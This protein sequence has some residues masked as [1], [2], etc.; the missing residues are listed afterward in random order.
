VGALFGTVAAHGVDGNK[1]IDSTTKA[2]VLGLGIL[3]MALGLIG[4]AIYARRELTKIIM[5]EQNEIVMEERADSELAQSFMNGATSE[6]DDSCSFEGLENPQPGNTSDDLSLPSSQSSSPTIRH[7]KFY[8]RPW[9]PDAVALELPI[10]PKMLNTYLSPKRDQVDVGNDEPN[11]SEVQSIGK[12]SLSASMPVERCPDNFQ[13]ELD[14]PGSRISSS[15]VSFRRH[16]V[17]NHSPENIRIGR[18][19]TS[20]SPI[21]RSSSFQLDDG[22]FH[23]L[24][25]IDESNV[26]SDYKTPTKSDL[27]EILNPAVIEAEEGTRRRCHTDPIDIESAPFSSGAKKHRRPSESPPHSRRDKSPA[28]TPSKKGRLRTRLSMDP[29]GA[30]QSTQQQSLP[31]DDSTTKLHGSNDIYD[32]TTRSTPMLFPQRKE[33]QSRDLR[34]RSSSSSSLSPMM[35]QLEL[36]RNRRNEPRREEHGSG[37]LRSDSLPLMNQLELSVRNNRNDS[38]EGEPSREWFWIWA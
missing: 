18:V 36:N 10:L 19:T 30:L 33:E 20:R 26:Y 29:S 14:N 38:G 3:F 7:W 2:V 9:T 35:N 13:S 28:L 6:E 21:H 27:C 5:D 25:D 1:A 4:T 22:N 31:P 12:K 23:G 24:A 16:S 15:N 8:R 37:R 34:R 32:S 17:D 11:S